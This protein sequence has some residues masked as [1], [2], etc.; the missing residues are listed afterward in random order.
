MPPTLCGPPPCDPPHLAF[1]YL[2]NQ[3]T[4]DGQ[5][6]IASWAMKDAIEKPPR[7]HRGCLPSKKAGGFGEWQG[8]D[9]REAE[10]ASQLE[11]PNHRY[12]ISRHPLF[13]SSRRAYKKCCHPALFI[14]SHRAYKICSSRFLPTPHPPIATH[15]HDPPVLQST[16]ISLFMSFSA[17][18]GYCTTTAAENVIGW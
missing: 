10:D 15:T 5:T 13:T 18:D 17:A 1:Y 3:C 12:S 8:G 6:T 7:H 4:P 2:S 16:T 9:A 14:I 11:A